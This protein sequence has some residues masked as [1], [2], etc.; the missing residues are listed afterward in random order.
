[1]NLRQRV[2]PP[3]LLAAALVVAA[4]L[5]SGGPAPAGVSLPATREVTLPNGAR[6]ILAE[7]HDVPLIAFAAYLRGGSLTDPPGKEGL[8]SLTAQMLRKG[9]GKR[10][11]LQI[12]SAA[13]GAGAELL[14][15]ANVEFT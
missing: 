15:G 8:A 11:A 5:V 12:A 6:L 10:T 4:I 9:A 3:R 1:M 2:I 7:K 13:D 14:T